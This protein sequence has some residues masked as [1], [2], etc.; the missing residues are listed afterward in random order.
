MKG[1]CMPPDAVSE[2]ISMI[3]ERQCQLTR[4]MRLMKTK[5]P[6]GL[7]L[8]LDRTGATP[9]TYQGCIGF[10]IAG[11]WAKLWFYT[12]YGPRRDKVPG[13]C[14]MLASDQRDK[15]LNSLNVTLWINTNRVA[16]IRL[17]D[18]D[19]NV[20]RL[21]WERMWEHPIEPFNETEFENELI[22]FCEDY[23]NAEL[24]V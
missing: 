21:I 2:T 10:T 4:A 17:F 18:A 7:K 8:N 19:E 16:N 24:Y 6:Y 13:R 22:E 23:L 11:Q 14:S 1:C 9:P 12:V 15:Y 20:D 3:S 5:W